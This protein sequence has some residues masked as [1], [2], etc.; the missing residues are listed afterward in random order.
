LLGANVGPTFFASLAVWPS[1]AVL[2][3]VVSLAAGAYP[4]LVLSRVRP[5][6]A[7]AA[8]QARTGSAALRTVLVG[9]QFGIASFLLIALSVMTAQ[10]AALRRTALA[11]VADPLVLIQNST[12]QTKVAPSS[13]RERLAA[14]PA[15]RGVTEI[16]YAPYEFLLTTSVAASPDPTAAQRTVAVREVG[17]DFFAVFDVPILAGRAFDREHA[18]DAAPAPGSAD[19]ARPVDVVVDRQLAADLGFTTPADAVDRLLYPPPSQNGPPQPP[20]RIVGV[21][22]SR[23]FTWFRAT[24]A[25]RGT[26]YRLRADLELTVAR[27]AAA[28]LGA[29]VAGIDS[30]W[31]DLAPNVAISR[32]F[33][34]EVF[35]RAY[36]FYTQTS[37]LF[38]V[39]AVMAFA[40][41][42]AGLFGMATFVTG[43]RRREM[44]VRKTLGAGSAQLATLLVI[45]FSRPV[46]AAN[47]IAWP[48]GYFAARAYLN[49]FAE[50]IRIEPWPFVLSLLVTLAI[51]CVAVAGQTL[52]AAATKPAEALR[53]E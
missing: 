49:Q 34:D 28:E 26:I 9:C 20:L 14:V 1:L 18:D 12:A 45:G 52:R 32:R 16:R 6:A 51:A 40:I 17:F 30:A 11:A 29:G 35:E 46:L 50:P 33:S 13:L 3:A 37:R 27:V 23:M 2:A 10:N 4:A 7:L 21:A 22:E 15:V 5:V 25:L 36:T 42:V 39:L 19:A 47:L 48:A 38:G 8:A 43:R 44:G 24:R 31:K 53:H 41:C